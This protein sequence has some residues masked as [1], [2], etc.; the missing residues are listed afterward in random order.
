MLT[1][2]GGKNYN[3]TMRPRRRGGPHNY[4]DSPTGQPA[5][6]DNSTRRQRQPNAQPIPH[7]RRTPTRPHLHHDTS[8]NHESLYHT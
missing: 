3:A 4:D 5:D 6:L 8:R 1:K 2:R 7:G